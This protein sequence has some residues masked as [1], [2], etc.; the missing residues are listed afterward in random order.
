MS[1][2]PSLPP[3][4]RYPVALQT[5]GWVARTGPFLERCQARY[6]DMFTLRVAQ[7]RTWV[8]VSHP[9]AVKQVFTADPA[10]ARAGE[11]NSILEPIVGS[12]S[13]LLLDEGAHMVQRKLLLPPL[14]GERIARYADLMTAIAEEEI[15]R[16][17]LGEPMRL[18]PRM[19]SVTLEVILRTVFGVSE[20]DRLEQL[21]RELQRLLGWTTDPRLLALVALIGPRRLAASSRFRAAR[22]PVDELLLDEIARRRG[23]PG[24]EERDDILSLLVQARHED[25]RPMSDEEVRDELVTMLVAGHET[26]ATALSWALERLVRHPDKLSGC[27]RR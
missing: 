18:L 4:P 20:R 10:V 23:A 3:G 6:G 12:Q 11:G 25:G 21:R 22:R 14:H 27:G 24:V 13:V 2:E 15:A 17:P 9:D 26:N 16:W 8:M 7:E 5:L 1:V 19:Q